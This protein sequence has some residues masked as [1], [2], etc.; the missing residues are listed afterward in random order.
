MHYIDMHWADFV[1]LYTTTQWFSLNKLDKGRLDE[2]KSQLCV[3]LMNWILET[4]IIS[5]KH[6]NMSAVLYSFDILKR[7]RII[8]NYKL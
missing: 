2:G 8:Q 7:T 3:D 4:Q 6:P 5:C 1:K